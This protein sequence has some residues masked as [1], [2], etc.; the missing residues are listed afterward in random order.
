M[1]IIGVLVDF[2]I[3]RKLVVAVYA[4]VKALLKAAWLLKTRLCRLLC[5]LQEGTQGAGC[6]SLGLQS[7][8]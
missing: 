6:H 7:S 4:A 8:H 1:A 2:V 3:T 5:I